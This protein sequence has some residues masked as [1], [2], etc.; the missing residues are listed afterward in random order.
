MDMPCGESP[1]SSAASSARRAAGLIAATARAKSFIACAANFGRTPTPT[2][3]FA[4]GNVSCGRSGCSRWGTRR[5]P[6]AWGGRPSKAGCRGPACWRLCGRG[7]A[8][9]RT[10]RES[11]PPRTRAFCRLSSRRGAMGRAGFWRPWR[12]RG[13]MW[14]GRAADRSPTTAGPLGRWVPKTKNDPAGG[15]LALIFHTIIRIAKIAIITRPRNSRGRVRARDQQRRAIGVPVRRGQVQGGQAFAI[16]ASRFVIREK[17]PQAVDVAVLGREHQGR[18][19]PKKHGLQ[20]ANGRLRGSR[21]VMFF[22]FAIVG[23]GVAR[24]PAFPLIVLAL[25]VMLVI[26]EPN[27]VVEA[28]SVVLGDGHG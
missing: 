8:F 23:V 14:I 6:W 17:L 3:L 27:N 11:R 19:T 28:A 1:R 5:K 22:N 25:V 12:A 7:N 20:E 9:W 13:L 18:P 21:R 4:C 10:R 2:R 16:G 24:I 15:G 26:K